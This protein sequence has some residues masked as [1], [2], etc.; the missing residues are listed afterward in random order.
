[1][2]LVSLSPSDYQP[3]APDQKDFGIGVVGCGGIVRGAHLPAYRQFGY[4]VAGCCDINP[5]AVRAVQEEFGIP[6]GTTNVD[7]LIH[8]D[9]VQIIDL[10]VHASVRRA[11]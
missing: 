9:D 7:D 4:R 11:V 3:S 6:F 2:P 5:E 10:A 1:M 8:R